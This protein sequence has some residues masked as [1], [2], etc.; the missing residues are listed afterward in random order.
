MS[1]A[2]TIAETLKVKVDPTPIKIVE[3][4]SEMPHIMQKFAVAE[5]NVTTPI[6]PGEMVIHAK[7]E[8]QIEY[9]G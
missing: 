5:S 8:V 1:K 6:E 4:I 3:E 7:V 2:Q 9:F